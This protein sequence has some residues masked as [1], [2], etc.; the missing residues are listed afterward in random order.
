MGFGYRVKLSM[1]RRMSGQRIDEVFV[2]R[3]YYFRSDLRLMKFLLKE[4]QVKNMMA[5]LMDEAHRHFVTVFT[6]FALVL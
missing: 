4:S 3:G 6:L 2:D 5:E 1:Y